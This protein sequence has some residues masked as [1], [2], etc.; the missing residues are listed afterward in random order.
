MLK[1][2][3]N[4]L[5]KMECEAIVNTANSEPVYSSGVD[6][7]V[8][9]AAGAE[10]LLEARRKIGRVEEGEVFVTDAYR[11]PFKKIIHAVSPLYIDGRSGEEDKLRACYTKSLHM[12]ATLDIKS[13]AFPIIATGSFGYPIEQ[14]M[15]IAIEE[16]N[17]FLAERDMLVYLVVFDKNATDEGRKYKP[18]L[19]S[20]I[21]NHYVAER[22]AA[23]YGYRNIEASIPANIPEPMP[24]PM[25]V[26][27]RESR[28]V[29]AVS[30]KKSDNLF[31]R[32][33]SAPGKSG[34][35]SQPYREANE[36]ALEDKLELSRV[37]FDPNDDDSFYELE[38]KL[39]TRLK[40]I[41]DSFSDY[42]MY[43]IES[44][45]MTPFEV[46]TNSV[47]TKKL[48]SKIKT[49]PEYHPS[50]EI[51]LRLC[52]GARLNIDDSKDLLSRAG[53]TFSPCE[54]YD[55]IF[56]FFIENEIFDIVEIAIQLE[57]HGLPSF[58]DV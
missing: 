16:I 4:D 24:M 58:I 55:L 40:H 56:E 31:T 8:Y 21:E 35:R 5:I 48:F 53:Y 17:S 39:N 49:N 30:K 1:I 6:S 26:M 34:A 12:A 2:V 27:A 15:S 38:E 46:Y 18:N 28:A 41:K 14:G 20:F 13:I 37:E 29:E 52:V 47:V 43:L 7:A 44:R 32:M 51:A 33:L 23:E 22:M 45:G 54:L 10:Q 50:K 19:E 25:P 11:L 36:D 3:R 9:E 57:E 42:L